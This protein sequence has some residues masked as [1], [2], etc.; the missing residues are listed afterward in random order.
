MMTGRAVGTWRAQVA[1]G[2]LR[3]IVDAFASLGDKQHTAI[4][5]AAALVAPFRG[6][7]EIELSFT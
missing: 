5:R 2:R 3:V 7:D 4:E 1:G 6:R